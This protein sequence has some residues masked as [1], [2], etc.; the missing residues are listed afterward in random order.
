MREARHLLNEISKQLEEAGCASPRLD[1][2]L[3]LQMALQTEERILMHHDVSLSPDQDAHLRTLIQQRQAGCP[4]SRLRGWR[5]FYGL[6][7]VINDATLDPR[8]DSECLV[9]AVLRSDVDHEAPLQIVDFGTGSGCLLLSLL[10]HRPQWHGFGID[11][12][13]EALAIAQQNAV[14]HQLQ[15]RAHFLQSDWDGSLADETQFDVIIS[16]P[17]YIAEAD[18]GALAPD[19]VNY[20]PETALFAGEDGLA[21]YR[22]LMP[23]L[24]RRLS[25]QGR[26]FLEI[27]QH[28]ETDVVALARKASLALRHQHCDLSGTIRCLEFT[29]GSDFA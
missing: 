14:A 28:Q 1:A 23:I 6:T 9:E 16:N 25:P 8:P 10:H 13:P 11:I 12:S 29:R 2:N 18:R 20:D 17:P 4:V 3:L 26:A 24:A 21:D 27:G 19:V 5:E 22:K 7:F 15:N